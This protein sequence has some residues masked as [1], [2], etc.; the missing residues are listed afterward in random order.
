MPI[1]VYVQMAF[2]PHDYF[3]LREAIAVHLKE[4]GFH[5]TQ[6]SVEVV[7]YGVRTNKH[8]DHVLFCTWSTRSKSGII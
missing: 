4:D 3:V 5:P 6:I 2:L 1:I 8:S 7:A